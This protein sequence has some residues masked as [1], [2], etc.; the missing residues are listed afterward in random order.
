MAD[1]VDEAQDLQEIILARTLH[2]HSTRKTPGYSGFCL[3]CDEPISK[4]RRYCDSTCRE[5]HEKS[6]KR[7]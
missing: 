7:R 2:K 1:V 3:S 6:T 4:D 5:D